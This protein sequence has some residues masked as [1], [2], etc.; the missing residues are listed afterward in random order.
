M[1]KRNILIILSLVLL[2]A[3][4]VFAQKPVAKKDTLTKKAIFGI[5]NDGKN[6]EPIV[7]VENGKLVELGEE[8][9]GEKTSAFIKKYYKPKT[10]YNAIFGGENVGSATIIK[11]FAGT[12][13]A[14]NQAEISTVST[15]FKPKGFLMGLATDMIPKKNTKLI[16]QLPTFTERGEINKLVMDEMLKNKV[17]IKNTGELRYH[18]LTKL[19]VDG[20]GNPEFVGTYWYNTAAKKRSL[21]FFIAEKNAKGTYSI[22]FTKFQEI[23][24][25]DV[26]NTD[27][28]ALDEGTYHELLLDMLDY[29]GDGQSEIFTYSQGFEGSNFNA[30]KRVDGKWTQVLE[31]SN[32]H[33]AF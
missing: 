18:N 31:T 27:I 29:D 13:C 12:D 5:F 26:M 9:S 10:K 17:P 7:F 16:R 32:Y 30:Y 23:E 21:L 2:L 11:D 14:A 8:A 25:K 22:P 20:D 19:D 4:S 1:K 3:A 6:L 24:E 15:K 33:C 28:K